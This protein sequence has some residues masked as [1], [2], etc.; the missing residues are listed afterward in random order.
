VPYRDLPS[1]AGPLEP[2]ARKFADELA[3]LGY[4]HGSAGIQLRWLAR[5]SDWMASGQLR[6]GQLDEA[7]VARF[8]QAQDRSRGQRLPTIRAFRPL[9]GWLRDGRVIAPAAVPPPELHDELLGRFESWLA[10]DRGL[11][12]RTIGRYLVT[13]RRLLAQPGGNGQTL[14]TGSQVTGFLL[15]EADRGLA[16][17]SL[18]GRVGE[19]RA[20][21]RFL[22]ASGE[23]PAPLAGLVPA[24]AGWRDA[25]IP[26]PVP[27]A[28]DIAAL[29]ASCDQATMTGLRDFAI[30][31]VLARLGLRAGEVAAMET[32]DI[33][34]RAG[35]IV[36]RGKGR[37]DDRMPLPPDAGR[38]LAAWLA[39]GRPAGAGCRT[40]FVTRHAPV[41]PMHP[42]TVARVVMFACERAGLP[43]MRS[44]RLRHALATRLLAVGAPLP[45]ISQV[46]RHR[47]LATTAIYAKVD[48]ASLRQ[49]AAPWAGAWQ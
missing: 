43:V 19:L 35:E 5:L 34:W 28:D 23:I 41:R 22:H 12:R 38:A 47:D 6:A 13:A 49:V 2:F 8:L 24:A 17:G 32:G 45:E 21:L 29:L 30:L 10:G 3:R 46:L 44:H 33:D 1:C 4:T 39:G 31:T 37:R 42:N 16:P 7:A 20:L 18:K 15:A 11:A 26:P 27:S 36:I 25:R 9:L 40:V 14:L 48:M